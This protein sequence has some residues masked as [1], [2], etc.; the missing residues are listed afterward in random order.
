MRQSCLKP[1]YASAAVGARFDAEHPQLSQTRPV[2]DVDPQANLRHLL[3]QWD[4]IGVADLVNDE[5]DC[6]LSPLLRRLGSGQGP[7]D[8]SEYLWSE[9]E[10]HFGL[11]PAN[12]DVDGMANRLV[13]WAATSL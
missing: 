2:T 5:Y 8:I 13:A 10:D 11:D 6:M 1:T 4:P 9:L 3:N 7:A 12:H